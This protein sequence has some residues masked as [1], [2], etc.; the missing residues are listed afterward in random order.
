MQSQWRRGV[1]LTQDEAD[2]NVVCVGAHELVRSKAVRRT[3]ERWDPEMILVHGYTWHVRPA[4]LKKQAQG[5]NQHVDL[6]SGSAVL[7]RLRNISENSTWVMLSHKAVVC[8]VP[9]TKQIQQ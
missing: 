6:I 2:H 1:W 8:T 9:D 7:L 5:A 3:D 4:T